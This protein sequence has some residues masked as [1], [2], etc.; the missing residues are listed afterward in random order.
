MLKVQSFRISVFQHLA[1]REQDIA[2]L[3]VYVTIAVCSL[4]L[5]FAPPPVKPPPPRE[6]HPCEGGVCEVIA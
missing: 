6:I 1:M 2:P 3:V 4:V 5:V